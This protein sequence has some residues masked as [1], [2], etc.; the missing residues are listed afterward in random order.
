MDVAGLSALVTAIGASLAL[1]IKAVTT[2]RCVRIN[3]PCCECT[4]DVSNV[5]HA[6]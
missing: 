3:M 4:R 6:E 2:S 1:V 5:E